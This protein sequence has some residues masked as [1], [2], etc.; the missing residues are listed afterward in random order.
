MT[1]I[2]PV[3]KVQMNNVYKRTYAFRYKLLKTTALKQYKDSTLI[4]H[5]LM[6]S[7]D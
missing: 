3:V 5:K 6:K 2:L 4:L 1:T 7:E